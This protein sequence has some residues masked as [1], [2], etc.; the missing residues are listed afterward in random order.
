DGNDLALVQGNN[1]PVLTIR[2]TD[3]TFFESVTDTTFGVSLDETDVT[4]ADADG[5]DLT[6]TLT[7]SL[8]ATIQV[9]TASGSAVIGTNNTSSVTVSGS[10][11]DINATLANGWIVFPEDSDFNDVN[12]GLVAVGATV[13]DTSSASDTGSFNVQFTAYNDAPSISVPIEQSTLEDTAII[14]SSANQNAISIADVDLDDVSADNE[15]VITI[16]AAFGTL[17]LVS[18]SGLS[19]SS[20]QNSKNLSF[21]GTLAAINTALET[22]LTYDPDDDFNGDDTLTITANDQGNS[23]ADPSEETFYT[24]VSSEDTGTTTS[25]EGTTTLTIDVGAVN[26]APENGLAGGT[27]ETTN[28]STTLTFDTSNGNLISISDVDVAGGDVQVTLSANENAT[29]TLG[30]TNDLDFAFASDTHGAPVGDGAADTIMTFR[31]TVAEVNAALDGLMLTPETGNLNPVS[32]TIETKDLG[33]TGLN[34][35]TV[36]VSQYE[37]ELVRDATFTATYDEHWAVIEAAASYWESVIVGDVNGATDLT[38]TFDLQT[39]DGE[40]GTLAFAGPDTLA[41]DDLPDTGSGT[42]DIA[43]IDRL[44]SEGTLYA[45]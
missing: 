24:A 8:A 37:I 32:L 26:D 38:I 36:P 7:A 28:E 34:D 2:G 21:T 1:A 25:E 40:F 33:N 11:A 12:G 15:L 19:S 22:G 9:T 30:Q 35:T 44:L 29:I 4:V 16:T 18:T 20:G 14:L 41:T 13:E 6:L 27:T 23:G 39:D 3:V 45:T 10:A 31:G 43:D 5:D 17:S 42:F